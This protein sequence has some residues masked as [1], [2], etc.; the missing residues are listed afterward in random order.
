MANEVVTT[1]FGKFQVDDR[2]LI[3][4]TIKAGTV[5]DGPGFLQVIAAGWTDILHVRP[6][7]TIL[8]V[9]AN[10]GAFTIWLASL[11]ALRVVAVE[12]IRQTYVRL[13]ANLDLNQSTCAQRVITIPCAAY[14][15]STYLDLAAPIDPHNS[16]EATLVPAGAP[17]DTLIQAEPLDKYLPL[18]GDKVSLIKIDAQGCDFH[19]LQGLE[20]TIAR[21]RP[22]IVFE[23]DPKRAAAHN[24]NWNDVAQFLNR[25]CYFSTQWPSHPDNF[26][27]LPTPTR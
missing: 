11:Y 14:S 25:L 16:G 24:V 20:Q 6:Q 5:W 17:S 3:E 1:P 27:A 7:T 9:G 23:W 8:D 22:A 21:H 26:L 4:A 13:L 10:V 12:P 18:Y 19:V 2:D 15:R